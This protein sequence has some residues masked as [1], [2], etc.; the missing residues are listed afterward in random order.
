VQFVQFLEPKEVG[1][2]NGKSVTLSQKKINLLETFYVK[3]NFSNDFLEFPIISYHGYYQRRQGCFA[4]GNRS[5]YVDT[6]GNLNA[7]PF[8]H[9]NSGNILSDAFED[10]LQ[11]MSKQG[12]STY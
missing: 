5:M 7:C 8:C 6:D 1:H 2:Y 11:I 10:Q 4:G 12:C 9:T 3:M